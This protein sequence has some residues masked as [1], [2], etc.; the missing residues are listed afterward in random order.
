[1]LDLNYQPVP[2]VETEGMPND[3][4]LKWRTTGIGGSDVSAIYEV[5]GWT[6]KRALYYAKKGLEKSVGNPFTLNFGHAVE[7]FVAN[8]FQVDFEEK[9]K[10]WLEA[11]LGC[12]IASFVIYK[13]TMMYQHPLYPFMQ[14]N[15]DYRFLITTVDGATIPGIFECKTT[16]YHIGPEKWD[17]GKVPY[18]YELQTR[19]YMSVMN[20]NFTIIACVWGNNESDFR[21]RLVTRDL[22]QEEE[23]I[24]MEK[25]FWFNHVKADNPPELSHEHAAQELEA[26]ESY[27]IAD[28]IKNGSLQ[29]IDTSNKKLKSAVVAYQKAQERLEVLK[30][31]AE[32][33]EASMNLSK[34]E[35]LECMASSQNEDGSFEGIIEANGNVSY[36]IKNKKSI[37]KTVDSSRLKEDLPEIYE[38]Y[39][40][41]NT[42]FRFAVKKIEK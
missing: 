26:I 2:V 25:D 21:A 28:R 1:M 14:A 3:E 32:E 27:S 18:E 38:K 16:S 39:I 8:Q 35:I 9:H 29:E 13:D 6:T 11:K 5:S 31:K 20:E 34:A 7:A 33:I 17:N 23:L 4:W 12:K 37:R 24:E 41:E 10:S 40:K 19:H 42:S 22:D 30:A 15:L 36:I